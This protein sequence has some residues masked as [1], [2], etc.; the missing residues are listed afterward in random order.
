MQ[1]LLAVYLQEFEIPKFLGRG[2]LMSYPAAQEA[3]SHSPNGSSQM[4]S[5]TS[6]AKSLDF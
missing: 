1:H 6:G 2:F 4:L 3:R 5:G